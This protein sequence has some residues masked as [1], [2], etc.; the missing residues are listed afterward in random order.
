MEQRGVV[1]TWE[2]VAALGG[3]MVVIG[4]VLAI[5]VR[6]S[7]RASHS[8]LFEKL[9]GRYIAKALGEERHNELARRID[10]VEQDVQD[11][12][13]QSHSSSIRQR[14]T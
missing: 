4:S 5:Y 13:R 2:A 9:N 8:D 1:M 14:A 10:S 3:W 12:Q 6:L 7:I 11:L